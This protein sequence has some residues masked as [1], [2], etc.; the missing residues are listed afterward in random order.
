MEAMIFVLTDQA[1]RRLKA[2]TLTLNPKAIT[3][4]NASRGR[5][6]GLLA[7]ICVKWM[8]VGS[9]PLMSPATNGVPPNSPAVKLPMSRSDR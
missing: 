9:L 1:R 5:V 2:T 4:P 7:V 3:V 6:F 8:A